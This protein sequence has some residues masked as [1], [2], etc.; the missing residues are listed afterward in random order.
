MV[1][2]TTQGFVAITYCTFGPF[3]PKAQKRDLR[4]QNVHFTEYITP[5]TPPVPSC[6]SLLSDDRPT[7]GYSPSLLSRFLSLRQYI[8][9]QLNI[10]NN[11]TY[12]KRYDI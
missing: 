6:L 8:Q 1:E 10:F 12:C 11:M 4:H 9:T 7:L 2:K 5:S 3:I